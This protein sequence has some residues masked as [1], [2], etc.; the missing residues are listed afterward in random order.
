MSKASWGGDDLLIVF[1]V[2]RQLE[3]Q[4]SVD[5]LCVESKLGGRRFVARESIMW[6]LVGVQE[7]ILW[8]GLGWENY[9]VVACVVGK[10]SVGACGGQGKH[11]VGAG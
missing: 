2:D 5:R 7:N 6:E 3:G 8:G 11:Y 1:C 4:R 10:H 9:S